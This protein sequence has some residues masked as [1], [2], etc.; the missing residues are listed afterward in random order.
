MQWK[1]SDLKIAKWGEYTQM[2]YSMYEDINTPSHQETAKWSTRRQHRTQNGFVK[3]KK[4]V[5]WEKGDVN[6]N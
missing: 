6:V 3:K 4:N 5:I 2:I 1:K